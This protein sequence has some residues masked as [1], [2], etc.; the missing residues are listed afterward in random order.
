MLA[1]LY[2]EQSADPLEEPKWPSAPLGILIMGKRQGFKK[3][4]RQ[5]WGRTAMAAALWHS[6]PY[7]K[8]YIL[9]VA[10]DIH[11]P[12]RRPDAQEVK[13]HLRQQFDISADYIILRRLS[14]CTLL[15][16]RAARVLSRAYRLH[17]VIVLTHLYHAARTQL[18]FNEV[19]PNASVIPVHPDILTALPGYIQEIDI[20]PDIKQTI[21]NSL[22]HSIDLGRE[23][24]VEWCLHTLHKIDPR[25]YVERWLAKRLRPN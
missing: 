25:G 1:M 5:L 21:E 2:P 6:A 8:P 12:D 23:Q 19:L 16:V 3:E 20:F 14:N 9:F 13:R 24:L 7:P 10:A 15:E 4:N 17:E 22:P 11:G 18:Y